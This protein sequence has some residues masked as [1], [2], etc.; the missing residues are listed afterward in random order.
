[1]VF[2]LWLVFF[3]EDV[4]TYPLFAIVD[5]VRSSLQSDSIYFC[6]Y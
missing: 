4:G 5:N 3:K 6:N 1:M 2:C